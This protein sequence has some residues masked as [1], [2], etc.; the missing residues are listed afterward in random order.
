VAGSSLRETIGWSQGAGDVW[1][2]VRWPLGAAAVVAA[3]S[4]LFA[5]APRRRQPEPTWL[6]F[7]AAVSAALWLAF[8]G[9]F[10]LY[11]D[12]ANTFGATYGPVAR[13]IGLLLWTWATAVALFFGLAFA[14]QLEAVRAGAAEPRVDRVENV[15]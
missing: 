9:A 11:L 14:A 2:V 8:V 1:H 10:A 15:V 5:I 13:T 7:G 12:V 6:A 3:V 4:L